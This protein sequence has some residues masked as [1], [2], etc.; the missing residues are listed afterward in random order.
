MPSALLLADR[1]FDGERAHTDAAA[2]IEDGRVR[3]SGPRSRLPAE[4]SAATE[5]PLPADTT[6]LPGLVNCHIH[7]TLLGGVDIEAETRASDAELAV[8]ATVNALRSLA[9]GVT[10]VRDL[11]AP[12]FA[13]IEVGKAIARGELV[14]PNILA[15]GRGIT[16]TGGHGWQIG[17]QADGPD[18]VRRA[19]REQ[20]FAGAAVIKIFSTGGLLGSGAHPEVA[21]LTLEET[22]AAVE[23]AHGHN[24]RITTHVHAT[25]GA[26]IAI[27]AGVDS[28]EHATLLDA[29]AIRRCKEKGIALVPTFAAIKA[30]LANADRLGAGVG[31]RAR[32]LAERH[33][34]GIRDAL[35][36]GVVVAAGADSGTA[37]NYPERF[38]VELEALVEVGM[39][40]ERALMAAT[41]VAAQ[42]IGRDDIG[43]IRP[44]ARADLLAVRGDP[45]AD[46][47]AC[48]SVA[49]VWKDGRRVET[50]SAAARRA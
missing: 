33:Q 41:S 23:E 20:V 49:G 45:L 4:A 40:P 47:R 25:A 8:R 42:V 39:T 16:T 5:V 22:R 12:T 14:G 44:G 24:L 17:R 31:D 1:L 15:A 38:V 28:I 3:W 34:Q 30:I 11:G 19:V 29:D 32:A 10:T 27:E 13:S 9:A 46:V 37:F 2:L 18:E 43:R 26:R 35:R 48:W 7:L 50:T 36:N 21:Q 6:L